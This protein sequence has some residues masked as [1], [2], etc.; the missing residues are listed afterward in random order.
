MV[1]SQFRQ[2]VPVRM[3]WG[4][5]GMSES[6]NA[7]SI[8]RDVQSRWKPPQI[9]P[10][11]VKTGDMPGDKIQINQSHIAKADTIFP[12]LLRRLETSGGDRVVVSVYGGSGVGKS[13]IASVLGEY[14]RQEGFATYVLSGDNYP[15]RIPQQNDLERLSTYRNA[16]L[17]A[18]ALD[19]S[20]TNARMS[21]LQEKWPDL[22]DMNPKTYAEEDATWMRV[23]HDAGR[24]DLA[25][26]LGTERETAFSMVNHIIHAFRGGRDQINLKRMGRAAD[27]VRYETVDVSEVRVLIIEW[28]HGNNPLLEGIDFPIFLFSTPA[29]TLAHRLARGRDKNADSPL[30]SLVLEIEHEKLVGQAD[31]AALIISKS[32]EV[33][34]YS[35]FQQRLADA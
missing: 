12:F 30:I 21:A 4:E 9:D 33:L 15:H 11:S 25:Q 24:L 23:Y 5:T 18:F 34:S 31:R 7:D 27:E 19:Q 10:D 13:E 29:E 1:Y 26:Y 28:T 3:A 35:D 20:F 17:S 2:R 22:E 6:S 16:A 32:G 14:C 8:D